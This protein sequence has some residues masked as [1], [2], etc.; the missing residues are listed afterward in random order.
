MGPK[1]CVNCFAHEWLRGYVHDKSRVTGDCDY[2]QNKGV[3]L[4]AIGALYRPFKNL[5]ELYVP[6]EDPHGQMLFDLIQW[7]YEV[8][9]ED[10][11]SSGQA[12][13]LLEDIMQTR[14]E[15]DSGESP[16]SAYELHYRRSSL[17]HHTTMAEAWEEFCQKVKEDPACEPYLPTLLDEELARMEVELSHRTILYRA[18]IGF[19]SAGAGGMKPFEGADI[20]AP[21]PDRAKA[22]RANE[23]REVRLYVADQEA[24][25]IAE[26]RPWRGL[27]VSVAEMNSIRD[28]RLVDLS[29]PPPPSNPFIDESPQY[30]LE[31]GD[32]LLAFGE[33]LGRPLRRADDPRDYVPCQKLVRFI[34]ECGL[35]D[36]IRYPSAMA[37]NGTN[38][39]LFDSR[40]ARIGPSKLV[41]VHEM[42][43]SYDPLEDEQ[44]TRRAVFHDGHCPCQNP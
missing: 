31:L 40:L 34:R 13:R 29:E 3:A 16:V 36:G 2:C 8:F 18:R 17:W 27:L 23:E 28:L 35:Y 11:H 26:V 6:S 38:V 39:V 10:L 32:L 19:V 15:K 30:E 22:G 1:C 42:A 24:T 7:D 4:I 20:G 43:I 9:E 12:A 33:E 21:P 14:W 25:A 44:T 37:P 5:M 41:E